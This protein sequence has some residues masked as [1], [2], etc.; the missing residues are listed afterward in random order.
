MRY[1]FQDQGIKP[2]RF[3]I[4]MIRVIRVICEICG[5]KRARLICPESSADPGGFFIVVLEALTARGSLQRSKT[6]F[7]QPG[8]CH[9]P[10]F[11][12]GT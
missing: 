6:A 5:L 12:L 3:R 10:P 8:P 2:Y 9:P 4:I 11:L 7:T 1:F